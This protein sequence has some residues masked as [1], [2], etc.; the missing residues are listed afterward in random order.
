MSAMR[1]VSD[2]RRVR[3]RPAVAS[4]DRRELRA[5]R[6]YARR[7][8]GLLRLDI[9]IGVLLALVLLLATPGV[10]YAAI[11]AVLVLAGCVV[12]TAVGRWRSHNAVAEVRRARTRMAKRPPQRLR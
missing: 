2:E 11:V 9:A 10:A 12:S 8:R 7:R 4:R 1:P 6:N 5:R 3:S